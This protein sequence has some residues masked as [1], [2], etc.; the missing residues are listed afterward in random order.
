M[1]EIMTLSK[2]S[3]EVQVNGKFD[4]KRATLKLNIKKKDEVLCEMK[5]KSSQFRTQVVSDMQR[6]LSVDLESVGCKIAGKIMF[7]KTRSVGLKLK[8]NFSDL[9]ET[10]GA[11]TSDISVSTHRQLEIQKK[12]FGEQIRSAPFFIY[13]SD[14]SKKI[15]TLIKI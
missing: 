13:N 11:G 14:F 12:L 7:N 8:L 1:Q 3:L 6:K 2:N 9:G 10:V 15:L 4:Q 5:L